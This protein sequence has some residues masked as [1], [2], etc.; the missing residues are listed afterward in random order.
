MVAG[1]RSICAVGTWIRCT[2][3]RG[4]YNRRS[5]TKSAFVESIKLG[6]LVRLRVTMAGPRVNDYCFWL[7]MRL[8]FVS[9][10]GI[11]C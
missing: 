5:C 8:F 9:I 1:I 2:C 3:V 11:S 4:A 6:A 7:F 10:D